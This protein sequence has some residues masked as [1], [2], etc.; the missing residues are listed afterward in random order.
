M[1]KTRLAFVVAVVAVLTLPSTRADA[2]SFSFVGDFTEDDD[3]QLFGFVLDAPSAVTLRSWSYAG[4]INAAG[5]TILRGGF[6]P[7]LALFDASGALIGQ[8]DDAGC[9]AVPAD[10]LTDECWDTNFTTGLL[11]P[12]TYTASIQQYD[13]FSLGSLAAGFEQ[14]GTGNFTPTISG[15]EE[16][17]GSFEDV[18]GAVP[19]CQRDSHWAFDILNVQEA[20][21]GPGDP[22][23]PTVVPEPT[24]LILVGS[25]VVAAFRRKRTTAVRS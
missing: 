3:V 7:I 9:P 23:G 12:G 17:T 18:S 15:C 11:A 21:L 16:G 20:V 2:A 24:T 1:M 14:Q 13:N 22:G 10:A 25:G 4:G 19:G 6:D 8:Q 5:A